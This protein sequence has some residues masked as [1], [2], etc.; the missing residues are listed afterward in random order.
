[1]D[2]KKLYEILQQTTVQLRKGAGVEEKQVGGIDVTEVFAMPHESQVDNGVVKVDLHFITIGVIKSK[3]EECKN[4]LVE[5]LADW[6]TEAF[7]AE[8][9]KLQDGPSYI[10][11]GGVLG[12]Q[13]AALQL[14]ALGSVLG[15][16]N[17]ITPKT[18]GMSGSEADSMAGS[19]FVMIDGFK[20]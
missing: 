18:L 4:E 9:P 10:H 17:I 1:M 3:A 5:I 7:G 13:G 12:D 8:V 6:P 15:L 2:T 19:G 11:A 20:T 14:F 16:W